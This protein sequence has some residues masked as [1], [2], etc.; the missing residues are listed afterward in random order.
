[1][2]FYTHSYSFL[3]KVCTLLVLSSMGTGC[4]DAFESECD[5]DCMNELDHEAFIDHATRFFV[6]PVFK[7]ERAVQPFKGIHDRTPMSA[8]LCA[9]DYC[10]DYVMEHSFD[11]NG[12]F[13]PIHVSY[14]TLFR[15]ARAVV[16]N[17]NPDIPLEMF[18]KLYFYYRDYNGGGNDRNFSTSNLIGRRK[19][20][21]QWTDDWSP[22]SAHVNA[23]YVMNSRMAKGA[24]IIVA[25]QLA[26]RLPFAASEVSGVLTTYGIEEIY[27]GYKD[28]PPMPPVY[29]R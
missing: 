24:L 22:D 12:N 23:M 4:L 27:A 20:S 26:K 28:L 1:M 9:Y 7:L 25:G 16:H 17:Y 18:D 11:R 5:F 8:T 10:E 6:H 13:V 19:L 2:Q 21:V 15:E 14:R 29:P 3:S